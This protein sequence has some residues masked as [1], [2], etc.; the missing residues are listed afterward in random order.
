MQLI[1]HAIV[2]IQW[3]DIE[4][5]KRKEKFT[6]SHLHF[7]PHKSGKIHDPLS[8][9][10]SLSLWHIAWIKPYYIMSQ[11]RQEMHK[12]KHTCLM[13]VMWKAKWEI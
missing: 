8:K 1:S 10:G 2:W 11:H 13:P 7:L 4:R 5:K 6:D 9:E 3:V 12:L